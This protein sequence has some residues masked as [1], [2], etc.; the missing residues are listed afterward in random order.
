MPKAKGSSPYLK[1]PDGNVVESRGRPRTA[2]VPG[3][4]TQR[5]IANFV[6][7]HAPDA[8]GALRPE[9][10]PRPDAESAT[11]RSCRHRQPG[12]A[13]RAARSGCSA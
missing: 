11:H 6:I 12:P 8:L 7:L 10:T 4:F 9:Q 13:T 5:V 3:N 2:E 1:D